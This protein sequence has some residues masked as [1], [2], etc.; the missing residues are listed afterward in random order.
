MPQPLREFSILQKHHRIGL[1]KAFVKELGWKEGDQ[2]I[3]EVYK[4]RLIV[5][6]ISK[7]RKTIVEKL[8]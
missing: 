5:E 8:K 6:N 7:G 2:L 3:L 4:G 1:K